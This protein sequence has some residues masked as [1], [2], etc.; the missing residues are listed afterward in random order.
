MS[1]GLLD[2]LGVDR[3]RVVGIPSVELL[4]D[5]VLHAERDGMRLA[6]PSTPCRA[7]GITCSTST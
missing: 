3:N 5:L 6:L 1:G 4:L 7:T 2:Q